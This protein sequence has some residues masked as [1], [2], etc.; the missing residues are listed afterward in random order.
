MSA[1]CHPLD[2][3]RHARGMKLCDLAREIGVTPSMVCQIIHRQKYPS[4]RLALRIRT[5]TAIPICRLYDMPD[6]D[7]GEQCG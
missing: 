6:E 7:G 4:R 2:A 5:V 1:V 3:W